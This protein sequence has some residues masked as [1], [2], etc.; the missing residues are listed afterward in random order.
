MSVSTVESEN[1]VQYGKIITKWGKRLPEQNK[2]VQSILFSQMRL[3]FFTADT[4]GTG[5]PPTEPLCK[6]LIKVYSVDIINM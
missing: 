2:E 1:L 4:L 6:K 5:Y 3:Y